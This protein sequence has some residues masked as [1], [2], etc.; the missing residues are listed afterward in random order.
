VDNEVELT[1]CGEDKK[2][3]CENKKIR[4]CGQIRNCMKIIDGEKK[5]NDE[6]PY[7]KHQDIKVGNTSLYSRQLD[8]TIRMNEIE[9]TRRKTP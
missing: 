7:R 9:E 8:N 1:D 2:L 3:T 6:K 4:K 5:L